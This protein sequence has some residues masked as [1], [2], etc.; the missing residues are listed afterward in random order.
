MKWVKWRSKNNL[1][2]LSNFIQRFSK[3]IEYQNLLNFIQADF[4]NVTL[5]TL[6]KT[7][8]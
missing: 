2:N 5:K 3:K 7:L 4:S 1:I 6:L 8:D